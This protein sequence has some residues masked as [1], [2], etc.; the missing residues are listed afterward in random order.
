MWETRKSSN[1]LAFIE[2][3][4]RLRQNSYLIVGAIS[5]NE[6]HTG[7]TIRLVDLDVLDGSMQTNA[8]HADLSSQ[9]TCDLVGS[10]LKTPRMMLPVQFRTNFL[11]HSLTS[12]RKD[13]APPS[14][15][16]RSS[17]SDPAD[18]EAARWYSRLILSLNSYWRSYP[19]RSHL[20]HCFLRT[21]RCEQN[22]AKAHRTLLGEPVRLDPVQSS[23]GDFEHILRTSTP[24][25]LADPLAHRH[26]VQFCSSFPAEQ[27]AHV[28]LEVL[29]FRIHYK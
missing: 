7:H 4:R 1:G 14:A 9:T 10:A 11:T 23:G 16:L 5:G 28:H 26:L 24:R 3:C 6:M 2:Q 21:I 20:I 29:R 12:T 15:A 25:V 19:L 8:V 22:S 27:I 17:D 18:L 13:R